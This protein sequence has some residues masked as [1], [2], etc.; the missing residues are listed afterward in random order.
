[1]TYRNTSLLQSNVMLTVNQCFTHVYVINLDRR[2]DRELSMHQKMRDQEISFERFQAVDGMTT[3]IPKRYITDRMSRGAWGYLLTWKKILEQS[4]SDK[5]VESIMCFDDDVIFHR[6]FKVQFSNVINW[7]GKWKILNLGASQHAEMEWP[8]DFYYHPKLTDGS[9]ATAVHRSVFHELL[10]EIEKVTSVLRKK[11]PEVLI[12]L[13]MPFDSGPL[14]SIYAKYPDLCYV[15]Y[16]NLVISDVRNST[17]RGPRDQIELS[18]KFGWNLKNYH[19]PPSYDKVSIIISCYNGQDSI[20]KSVLSAR[21]QDYPNCEVIVVDDGST[22]RTPEILKE[23]LELNSYFT[24]IDQLILH[25][26]RVLRNEKNVGCYATRNIGILAS[27]GS[28]ITFQDADD[29]SVVERVTIQFNS[30]MR[31]K[32]LFTTSLIL[33]SHLPS[34]DNIHQFDYKSVMKALE[35]YR[36]HF[37]KTGEYQYCC[38][39]IL[40]MVTTF[41]S[42]ELFYQL[43]LYWELPCIADAEFC[44]RILYHKTGKLFQGDESVVSYLAHNHHIDGI[45]HKVQQILYISEEMRDSNITSQINNNKLYVKKLYTEEWRARLVGKNNYVYPKML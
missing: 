10:A 43:G 25:P 37:N 22:D 35:E 12:D 16:P 23:V 20:A 8:T 38:K 28:W 19:W 4:I 24:D 29:I 17:I 42:R 36:I 9:F 1:M 41:M 3:K 30:L 40:G 18:L 15:I 33:R 2:P 13:L 11:G 39:S 44:E 26:I 27:K 34:F 21:L 7:L 32:V 31:H 5:T 45:Y 14:R 6:D